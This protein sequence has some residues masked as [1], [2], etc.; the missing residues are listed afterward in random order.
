MSLTFESY[1]PTILA[2]QDW[3]DAG[4]LNAYIK[5]Q[6]YA[7]KIADPEGIERS[8]MRRIGAWH[9]KNNL[10]CLPEFAN[11][12]A[13]VTV[14]VQNYFD[15]LGYDPVWKAVCSDMW[16]NV[17]PKYAY[18]RSHHHGDSLCS[19][20]YYIQSDPSSGCINFV[21]PREQA[22]IRPY[23][24]EEAFKE[25]H[26]TWSKVHFEPIPGRLILFPGWLRHDVDPNMSEAEGETSNR[27]SISFNFYQK[28]RV[29]NRE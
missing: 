2:F 28:R 8:N 10:N 5:E 19:G 16:A 20:V 23:Y 15:Q 13:K 27:I 7:L 25:R 24:S 11:F 22:I 26:H 6:I 21:D 29:G 9:S 12:T 17:S 18:S 1:F 3:S 14:A 4:A